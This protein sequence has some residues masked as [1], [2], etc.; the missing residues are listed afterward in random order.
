MCI[1]HNI[2]HLCFLK[3]VHS[4]GKVSM[5]AS[6][7]PLGVMGQNAAVYSLSFSALMSQVLLT[8]R[9]HM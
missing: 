7:G 9:F 1:A 2:N 5:T 8:F 4:D 3:P 6:A